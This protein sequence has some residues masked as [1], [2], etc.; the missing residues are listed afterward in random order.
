MMDNTVLYI[1]D[2]KALLP[3]TAIAGLSVYLSVVSTG[4]S[5]S[6]SKREKRAQCEDAARL[7]LSL[8]Y[9]EREGS[10]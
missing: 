6:S 1:K 3:S 8:H 7:V 5:H 4:L 10:A 2:R 9:C